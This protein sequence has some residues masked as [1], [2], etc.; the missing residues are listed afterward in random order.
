MNIRQLDRQIDEFEHEL[1][2]VDPALGRRF[3]KFDQVTRRRDAT[4]F[5]LLVS[6]AVL[7]MIGLA[8]MSIVAWIAG[9]VSL[10]A[11]F[12]IDTR[13]ERELRELRRAREQ[14]HRPRP[15]RNMMRS[16]LARQGEEPSDRSD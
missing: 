1:L 4:V 2:R 14:L 12:S 16:R 7:L 11:S 8:T 6:S 9:A 15:H 10:V 5:A 13:H 3:E